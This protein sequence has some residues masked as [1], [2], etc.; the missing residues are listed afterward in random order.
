MSKRWL[1]VIIGH[2]YV[3]APYEGSGDAGGRYLLCTRCGHEKDVSHGPT[4]RGPGPM[5]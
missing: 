1:C 4:Q 3:G 5:G 2:K